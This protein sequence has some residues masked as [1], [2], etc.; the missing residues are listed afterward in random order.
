MLGN[1]PL[2]W[3][4]EDIVLCYLLK[5]L[6]FYFSHLC[7]SLS[8]ID[9][10]CLVR[11]RSPIPFNGCL[12]FLIPFMGTPPFPHCSLGLLL[13]S[14][15][16]P[17]ICLFLFSFTDLFVYPCANATYASFLQLY[18]KLAKGGLSTVFFFSILFLALDVFFP[19]I[20]SWKN[21]KLMDSKNSLLTGS[22][23]Y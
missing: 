19:L 18:S 16:Y 1:I 2:P 21:M 17:Y 14:S 12:I 8:G 3:D 4:Y 23:A 15:K 9:F 7:L 22:R 11:S 5:A 20:C 13:S 6:W 10:L